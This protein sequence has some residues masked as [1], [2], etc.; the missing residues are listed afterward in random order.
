M[1]RRDFIKSLAACSMGCWA[2]PFNVLA[3]LDTLS[4]NTGNCLPDFHNRMGNSGMYHGKAV[5]LDNKTYN[6]EKLL[7]DYADHEEGMQKLYPSRFGEDL[8]DTMIKEIREEF[9]ALIPEIPY[10]GDRNP[11]LRF[12]IPCVILLAQYRVLTK[13][14]VTLEEF[15]KLSIE[16]YETHLYSIPQWRRY[17]SGW[18]QC[19]SHPGRLLDNIPIRSRFPDDWVGTFLQGDGE[20]FDFGVDY[21]QCTICIFI[22]SQGAEELFPLICSYDFITSKAYNTGYTRTKT[23][24]AGDDVCNMRWKWDREVEIPYPY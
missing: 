10:I 6:K 20:E 19:S 23:L 13:Y 3:K 15:S 8:A 9:E 11:N 24:S 16:G 4:Q 7:K 12:L 17:L 21:T 2:A 1:K 14:D 18:L 5:S 22:N